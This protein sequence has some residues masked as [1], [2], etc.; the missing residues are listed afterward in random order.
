MY[1]ASPDLPELSDD[2]CDTTLRTHRQK[3]IASV[4][5]LDYQLVEKTPTA[6]NPLSTHGRL[7][8]G[9]TDIM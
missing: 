1:N 5:L 9:E 7:S 3:V 6:L 2:L 4:L 8:E